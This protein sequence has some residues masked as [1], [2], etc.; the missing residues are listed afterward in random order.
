MSVKRGM[1]GCLVSLLLL[2]LVFIPLSGLPDC[3][4]RAM[5]E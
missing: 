5:G 4:P 1:L 3:E 2:L